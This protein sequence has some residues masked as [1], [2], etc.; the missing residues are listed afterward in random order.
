MKNKKKLIYE[1][2]MLR[3]FLTFQYL[4]FQLMKFIKLCKITKAI[5]TDFEEN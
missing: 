2:G 1:Y 4:I 5:M 3:N